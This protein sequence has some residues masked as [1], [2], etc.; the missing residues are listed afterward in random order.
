MKLDEAIKDY[1]DRVNDR[2]G[3]WT[4]LAF[5]SV[6]VMF[7]ITISSCTKTIYVPTPEYH[8]IHDTIVHNETIIKEVIKEVAV[9][10]SSS[11]HQSGDTIRIE[12][13]HY[14]RDYTY[15]KALQAKVDSL[16]QLKRDSVPYPVEVPVEVPAQLTSWQQRKLNAFFP[17]VS[18]IALLLVHIFRKPILKLIAKCL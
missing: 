11:F 14:E 2:C 12:H 1:H 5:Y 7:L 10:D 9:K 13:W 4:S 8:E 3:C 17:M 15:E 18:L 16:T 6:L